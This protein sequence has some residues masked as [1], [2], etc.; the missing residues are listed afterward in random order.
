MLEPCLGGGAG[1]KPWPSSPQE[2]SGS[3]PPGPPTGLSPGCVAWTGIGVP[4]SQPRPR[5]GVL[6]R[7]SGDLELPFHKKACTPKRTFSGHCLSSPGAAVDCGLFPSWHRM[8]R[9]GRALD[10]TDE[11]GPGTQP[12]PTQVQTRKPQLHDLVLSF[13][14]Q[15][16]YW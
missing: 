10:Q 12:E 11:A 4:Q 14:S 13:L 7:V 5:P 8:V 9:D 2:T 1:G 16:P 3:C 15:C 6:P